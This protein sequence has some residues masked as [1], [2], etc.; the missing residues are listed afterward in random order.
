MFQISPRKCAIELYILQ[1]PCICETIGKLEIFPS[2]EKGISSKEYTPFLLRETPWR[3]PLAGS[4]GARSEPRA[5]SIETRSRRDESA[6]FSPRA[7]TSD[8]R[9]IAAHR[10]SRQ[11]SRRFSGRRAPARVASRYIP[12]AECPS[13]REGRDDRTPEF[14]ARPGK[15]RRGISVRQARRKCVRA[16]NALGTAVVKLVRH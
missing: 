4:L 14:R 15:E 10:F 7:I 5:G 9:A 8:P 12:A 1:H 3:V 6:I 16:R 13:I 2:F 11:F